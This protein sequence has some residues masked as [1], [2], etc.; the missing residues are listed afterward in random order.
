MGRWCGLEGITLY[1]PAETVP[2]SPDPAELWIWQKALFGGKY[3]ERIA[4]S[5]RD[6]ADN[7]ARH[8]GAG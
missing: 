2:V 6:S 3:Q 4:R 8:K 1:L 7:S 5:V